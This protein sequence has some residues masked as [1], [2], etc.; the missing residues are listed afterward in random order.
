MRRNQWSLGISV[1]FLLIIRPGINTSLTTQESN[2]MPHLISPFSS[3]Q[4]PANHTLAPPTII[5]PIENSTIVYFLE[6]LNIEWIAA[7]DSAGHVITYTLHYLW[8]GNLPE[9]PSSSPDLQRFSNDWHFI[10][11]VQDKTSFTW[12]LPF[13]I[14]GLIYIRITSTCSVGLISEDIVRFELSH[15]IPPLLRISAAFSLIFLL[16]LILILP[17]LYRKRQQAN[18]RGK[19]RIMRDRFA[20]GIAIGLFDENR[21]FRI[22]QKNELLTTMLDDSE[23][24]SSLMYSARMYQP[25]K[26]DT[27][28][29]PFPILGKEEKLKDW[30]FEVYW[31][32]LVDKSSIDPR[33]IKNLMKIPI[34]ILLV[35]DQDLHQIFEKKRAEFLIALQ[36]ATTALKD[37]ESLDGNSCMMIQEHILE[38]LQGSQ[39]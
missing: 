33:I 2:F 13:I 24:L 6:S 23:I 16:I 20:I 19:S 37:V 17:V 21:G 22:E 11:T 3:K 29:G 18:L 10:A 32:K 7:S 12:D 14:N 4:I 39:Q 35:Y 28:F 36:T 9:F 15:I 25:D 1:I 38:S 5:S 26:L 31:T 30:I 8:S 34:A 27:L